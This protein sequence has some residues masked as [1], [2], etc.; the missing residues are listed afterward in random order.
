VL[1]KSGTKADINRGIGKIWAVRGFGG[2]E[3]GVVVSRSGLAVKNPLSQW[4]RKP[5]VSTD[6]RKRLNSEIH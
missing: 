4:E 3:S 5:E 2:R 6:F 1:Q